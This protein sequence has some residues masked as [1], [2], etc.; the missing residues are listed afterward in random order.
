MLVKLN[1]AEFEVDFL[2]YDTDVLIET[3]YEKLQKA[4]QENMKKA[5]TTQMRQSELIKEATLQVY[6]FFDTVLGE[7]ASEKIFGEKI[8]YGMALKMLGEFTLQKQKSGKDIKDISDIY[9]PQI[10]TGT[11]YNGNRQQRRAQQKKKNKGKSN[12]NYHPNK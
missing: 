3:E 9:T 7:G 2:D 11:A 10:N 5:Q 6:G 4:S 8:N 12:P 1:G